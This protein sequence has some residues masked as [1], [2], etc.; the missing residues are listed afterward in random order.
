[1]DY[2]CLKELRGNKINACMMESRGNQGTLKPSLGGH[3]DRQLVEAAFM[4][5]DH[6]IVKTTFNSRPPNLTLT[7]PSQH[8]QV[9]RQKLRPHAKTPTITLNSTTTPG[10]ASSTQMI[11]LK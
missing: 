2:L 1:M 5:Q 8:S 6:A 3:S 11:L 10:K 7:P 4:N 9:T